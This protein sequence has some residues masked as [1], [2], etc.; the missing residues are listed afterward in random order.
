MAIV[1]PAFPDIL[2]KASWDKHKSIIAKLIK[3]T[4][5]TGVADAL[6]E[7]KRAYEAVEWASLD[8]EKKM[9]Q[10]K[11]A[12]MTKLEELYKDAKAQYKPL[13]YIG[14]VCKY[15]DDLATKAA[16]AFK[17]HKLIPKSSSEH[18]VKLAAAAKKFGE[19]CASG[20]F[21]P[22]VEKAY[23]QYQVSM[24]KL[25]Q[26]RAN[27]A[28]ILKEAVTAALSGIGAIK[29][30]AEYRKFWGQELRAVGTQLPNAKTA[31]PELGQYHAA[32]LKVCSGEGNVPKTD[33]DVVE[34]GK[35]IKK[36]L[37]E[38]QKLL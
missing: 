32:W 30:V 2:T 17:T 27:A 19:E 21:Q 25:E 36:L 14:E 12:T 10:G 34:K 7:I 8:I 20:K 3:D 37:E 22:D 11:E 15:C 9:P 13:D 29:T 6:V 24:A 28:K 26:V 31:K 5:V 1:K 23:K 18:A 16:A 4:K 38:I 35:V 33:P